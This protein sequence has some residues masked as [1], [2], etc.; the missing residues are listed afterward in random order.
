MLVV[1][2]Y[3]VSKPV[4]VMSFNCNIRFSESILFCFLPL[5][6]K[7]FFGRKATEKHPEK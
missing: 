6:F 1:N 3:I 4:Y 2:L 5:P 7:I